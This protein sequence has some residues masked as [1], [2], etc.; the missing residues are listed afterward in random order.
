MWFP[1]AK[2]ERDKNEK[3]KEIGD[4]K[5]ILINAITN[6][7]KIMTNSEIKNSTEDIR[8]FGNNG[9][10]SFYLKLPYVGGEQDSEEKYYI[11]IKK[12]YY[13]KK[14]TYEAIDINRKRYQFSREQLK[15]MVE[16]GI[17]IAGTK[18][19]SGVFTVTK[20]LKENWIGK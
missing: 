7:E 8:G 1:I 3:G 4:L 11:L 5:Y 13:I 12:N 17:I 15:E 16:Q 9:P 2:I 6:E 20:E 19:K 14:V 10:N 18:A